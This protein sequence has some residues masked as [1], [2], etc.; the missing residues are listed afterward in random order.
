Q[1]PALRLASKLDVENIETVRTGDPLG[2]SANPVSELRKITLK[3]KKWAPA[4]FKS[5][6]LL[7]HFIL[8][9]RIPRHNGPRKQ[10]VVA[11][12][13]DFGLEKGSRPQRIRVGFGEIHDRID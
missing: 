13:H 1:H 3:N 5:C 2:D 9:H 7:E 11:G 8:S 10:V 6:R 4:H 12:T